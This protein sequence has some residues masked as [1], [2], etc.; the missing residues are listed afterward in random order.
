MVRRIAVGGQGEVFIARDSVLARDVVIKL[1]HTDGD[2]ASQLAEARALAHVTHPN[3][4]TIYDVGIH[5]DP[6]AGTER[7]FLIVEAL[8]G[9]DLAQ[10]ATASRSWRQRLELARA[11]CDGLA[12]AHAAGIVHGDIKPPNVVVVA[13]VPKLVDFGMS[14]IAST[15][16]DESLTQGRAGGWTP[17]Y[18]APELPAGRSSR[19]GDQYALCC[20]L[21]GVLCDVPQ[22][23]RAAAGRWSLRQVNQVLLRGMAE[24]PAARWPTID[25]L[26][27]ALVAAAAGRRWARLG[28]GRCTG[29]RWG[30]R[31]AERDDVHNAR[32]LAAPGTRAALRRHRSYARPRAC[33]A[34]RAGAA[35]LARRLANH[36]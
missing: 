16:A 25:A 29:R 4:L 22:P 8:D 35:A 2:A 21:R 30:R 7:L 34:R 18:L 24:D 32:A 1:R 36:A 17:G 26:R 27:D 31:T 19:K 20:T 12:V 6:V 33:A 23:V 5:R 11:V 3:I 10:W 28:R 14:R 9:S 15:A 13:D